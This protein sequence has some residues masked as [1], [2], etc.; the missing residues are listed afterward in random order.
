MD[1]S[2]LPP[3]V[4]AGIRLGNFLYQNSRMAAAANHFPHQ[5]L[6]IKTERSEMAD[7]INS[8]G[9][10][11][12]ITGTTSPK[13]FSPPVMA[14]YHAAAGYPQHTNGDFHLTGMKV[15]K[16]SEQKK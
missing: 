11:A 16:L 12:E 13:S 1:P 7:I 6:P 14:A 8:S 10:A 3:E 2:L 15:K 4:A 9:K 5:Q